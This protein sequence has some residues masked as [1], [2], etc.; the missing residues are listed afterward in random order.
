LSNNK[1]PQSKIDRVVELSMRGL[2]SRAIAEEVFGSK[3]K[4]STVN[5]ILNRVKE[6]KDQY[7]KNLQDL[8]SHLPKV[9][10]FDIETSPISAAVWNLW[11]QNVGLNQI[12]SEWFV[13]S[14]AAKWLGDSPD[15]VMYSDLR[16]YVAE[17]DDTDLLDDMWDLLDEADCVITQNGCNFDVKKLNARFILNGYQPPSSYKHIDTLQI[18]KKQFGFTSNRLE[19][20]TDKLCVEFKK[21]KHGKFPGF[22][23]WKGMLEDN[24]DAWNE[25]EEYNIADVLSLE[26]LYLKMAAW[27]TS[28]PNFNLYGN[29]EKHVCRCGSENIVEYGYAYTGVSKFQRYRCK[30]CGAE[31][32]GRVN[33]LTKE[34]R[35]SLHMN[36]RN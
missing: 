9:L 33:L 26:E 15:N 5:N 6:G 17:E 14:Y 31:T 21:L 25:C 18:A 22:D 7:S 3:S 20:M 27:D 24:L 28:H 36:V 30:D 16:G 10:I 12:Q 35:K 19:W 8:K 29:L 13:L 23:L 11:K 32:R 34:K 2:K 1:T 4:K